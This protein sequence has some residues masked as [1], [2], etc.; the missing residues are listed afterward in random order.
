MAVIAVAGG[1]GDVGRTIVE[2]ISKDPGNF[3]YVLT[4]KLKPGSEPKPAPGINTTLIEVDYSSESGL[5]DVLD[6]LKVDTVISA[7]NLH[8][9]GASDAQTNLI[10]AA[11]KAEVADKFIPSEY[12]VD[13]NCS[14]DDLPYPPRVLYIEAARELERHPNLTFT[15]I[16][17][18]FFMDYLGLPYA[19]THLHPLY[20]VLDLPHLEAV[21]PGDGEAY[22]V[23]TH[24]RDV[25]KYVAELL[26][27][28]AKEWP[29]ESAIRGEMIALKDIVKVAEKVTG[30]SFHVQHDAIDQL[31]KGFTIELPSN[32]TCYAYFPSGKQELDGIVSTHMLGMA[33]G[34]FNIP[35]ASLNDL[36]PHVE[37]IR[38][39]AFLKTAWTKGLINT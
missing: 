16:R 1:T 28:P 33:S 10:R 21:I 38:L 7:L 32:K 23:F 5:T 26:K 25:G 31:R 15:L 4:R 14:E 20:F 11:S 9:P 2:E 30:K 12:N 27:L 19:E 35:G 24:S 18:G 17:N 3:V 34:V 6:K 13:W 36:L 39:E 22:A 37:P 29:R 8:W